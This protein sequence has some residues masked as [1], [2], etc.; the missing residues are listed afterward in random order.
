MIAA[1]GAFLLPLL[2]A[3]PAAADG[4]I[5]NARAAQPVE[6][7]YIVTLKSGQAPRQD[8][9]RTR[10]QQLTRKYSGDV[11]LVYTSVVKGFQA[12]LSADRARRLAAD[13]AVA[14]VEQDAISQAFDVQQNPPS[15]GLDR[16]DQKALPLSRSYSYDTKAANVT[17]YVLDTGILTSHPDF[18][19]RARSGYDF[20][21]NDTDANDCQGHGTHVAG[22]IGGA[23]Y[24]IAKGAKLVGVR[25]LDCN[26]R[27]ANSA[28]IKG[29]DWVTANAVKPAVAN[30]SLGGGASAA[31]DDAVKRAIASGV[32]FSLA[33]GNS[34]TNACNTSPART[35][36]ALTVGAT[37][38]TDARASFSNYGSCLD[39]FAPGQQIVSTSNG[40]GTATMSGTSMAAPHVAG[41]A[42]LVLADHPGHSPA[43]VA[44]ALTSAATTGAV[45]N[46]GNGS[47]NRL[48]FTG[49]ADTGTPGP[50]PTPTPSPSPSQPGGNWWDQF[51]KW[52]N[53]LL[54]PTA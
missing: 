48:L 1:A 40:G 8:D 25:V 36:A 33:A 29:I 24:G 41:A 21:D 28:I 30:M 9:V 49:S 34:N 15:W 43:Q 19:G 5:L 32:T 13:P 26:G 53:G 38:A 6:G 23:S 27:G 52:L 44:S 47:A 11:G 50:D 45:G 2:A 22:T 17:A 12:R 51:W 3:T 20:I 31:L 7:S 39:L 16:A 37:T 35:P 4:E 42:A 54:N 14:S 10:A 18:G 46:P